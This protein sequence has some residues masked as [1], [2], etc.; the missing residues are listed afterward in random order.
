MFRRVDSETQHI[1][2]FRR[3]LFRQLFA[4]EWNHSLF[5]AGE[6]HLIDRFIVDDPFQSFDYF[7]D[8]MQVI[9]L[10]V[11]LIFALRHVANCLYVMQFLSLDSYAGGEDENVRAISIGENYGVATILVD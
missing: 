7:L 6:Y 1:D 10:P 3:K 2:Y 8:M 11:T 9:I 5:V 4:Q